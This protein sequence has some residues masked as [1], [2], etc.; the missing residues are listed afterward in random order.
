MSCTPTTSIEAT[1]E[2]SMMSAF[3]LFMPKSRRWYSMYLII[4]SFMTDAFAKNMAESMRT[5]TACF[6]LNTERYLFKLRNTSVPGRRPSTA[7]RGCETEATRKR[8]DRPTLDPIP[9]STPPPRVARK[10]KIQRAKSIFRTFKMLFTSLKSIREVTEL[11][12]MQPKMH[13]GSVRNTGVSTNIIMRT[14]MADIN[15]ATT[16]FA[17]AL[18]FKPDLDIAPIEG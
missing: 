17:P 11:T 6:G 3:K 4:R 7:V 2:K 12:T 15:E 5:I 16:V 14:N 18:L 1:D 10:E 13:I 9:I 8:M